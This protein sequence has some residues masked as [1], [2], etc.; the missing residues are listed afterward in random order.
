MIDTLLPEIFNLWLPHCVGILTEFT[1]T[2]LSLV[3]NKGSTDHMSSLKKKKERKEILTKLP[4]TTCM[5]FLFLEIPQTHRTPR[6]CSQML[7]GTQ[8]TDGLLVAIVF[9][10]ETPHLRKSCLLAAVCSRVC[11]MWARDWALA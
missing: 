6:N 2:L 7:P 11:S 3:S 1:R 4:F 9:N 5:S 10:L 8:G